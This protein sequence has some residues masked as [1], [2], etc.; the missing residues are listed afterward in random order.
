MKA[1]TLLVLL[2]VACLV[3]GSTSASVDSSSYSRV[4]RG[5][6]VYEECTDEECDARGLECRP[7]GCGGSHC[8]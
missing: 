8:V 1:T 5:D 6:C 4:K 2:A 3:V 7:K